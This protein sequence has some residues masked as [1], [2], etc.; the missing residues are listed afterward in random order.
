[1]AE[2]AEKDED[3]T[4]E[5]QP[6]TL[7]PFSFHAGVASRISGLGGS[8][9]G[10]DPT[11]VF[12]TPYI[13]AA[14]G[15]AHF[16]VQFAGLKARRGTLI[17]RVNMLATEPGAHARLANSDRIQ[18]NRL[19]NQGGIAQI[20]FEGFRGFSFAVHGA[21]VD[22]TDAEAEGLVCTLDRPAEPHADDA[23]VSDG[24]TSAFGRDVVKPIPHLISL[25]PPTLE[26]PVSQLCTARQT[27][28]PLFGEW[29]RRLG[30]SAAS[31]LE[32]WQSIY[33]L[34]ALD[35][36]GMLQPGALGVGLGVETGPLPAEMAARDISVVATRINGVSQTGTDDAD[37]PHAMLES[38][39]RP[40]I[41]EP[42]IFATNVSC[43]EIGLRPLP[44]DLVNFDFAWSVDVMAGIGTIAA[45]LQMIE[46]VM[47]CLRPGGIAIHVVPYRL[48]RGSRTIE[49]GGRVL[50]RRIDVERL[51]VLL[52]SR[53]IEVAQIKIHDVDA[54]TADEGSEWCVP[55]F[56]TF[57]VSALGIIIRKAPAIV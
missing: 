49:E 28:E 4:Q 9:P 39:Q 52:I 22:D 6:V 7:D 1:M 50:F 51:G 14:A 25:E 34:R 31:T 41:C 36:Y 55:P 11:Y 21:I 15:P 17:L 26:F 19:V 10:H 27:A 46:D 16:T 54:I 45:G 35:S 12:H 57:D 48:G 47:A 13:E 5:Q 29:A 42:T 40:A 8:A 30:L 56:D 37:R 38:L 32:Q 43:R 23:I 18:L 33:I 3:G 20:K 2:I 24:R 44:K 53:N